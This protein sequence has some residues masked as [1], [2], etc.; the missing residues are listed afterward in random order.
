MATCG[1]C[2]L[3]VRENGETYCERDMRMLRSR[4]NAG[5]PI[6]TQIY[7]RSP[8]HPACEHYVSRNSSRNSGRN[9]GKI[10]LWI[11]CIITVIIVFY[12]VACKPDEPGTPEIYFSLLYLRPV[13]KL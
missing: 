4:I 9:V 12:I 3:F 2:D 1:E 13:I 11:L 10:L 6:Y 5:A 8:Y 7:G